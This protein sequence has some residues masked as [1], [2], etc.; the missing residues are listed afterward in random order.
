MKSMSLNKMNLKESLVVDSSNLTNRRQL[1]TMG[2]ALLVA[3]CIAVPLL[4][5]SACQKAAPEKPPLPKLGS[6]GSFSLSDQDG[7][8]IT[9]EELKG[10]IWIAAFVFTR[11]PS[12][13]PKV[14]KWMVEQQK[15]LKARSL[16]A[17]MVAISVDPDNDTPE[18]MKA[19]GERFSVDGKSFSL[20]SGDS[21]GIQK[22][23]EEGFKIGF[24]GK[25]DESKE[26]RGISHGSHAVLVGP[27][28][29]IRGYYRTENAEE[30]AQLRTPAPELI[31][32]VAR[33]LKEST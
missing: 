14:M 26:D 32:D 17:R 31:E 24:S 25:Y 11:C 27:D 19:Y 1:L 9:A 4:G 13:C 33:L 21:A 22:L 23:A 8:K 16:Q 28:L 18:K 10:Q 15:Q 12:I 6:V 29:E 2:T 7:K 3:P 5:L 20:L 30:K